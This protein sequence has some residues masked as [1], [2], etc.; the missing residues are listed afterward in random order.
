MAVAGADGADAVAHGGGAGSLL[1]EQE[2]TAGVV[3]ALL[4]QADDDLEGEDQVAE[5]VAVQRVPVPGP[6]AQQDLRALG[7]PSSG[8]W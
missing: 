4:V 5:Q 7:R 1:D 6:V 8:R 3:G 2:L